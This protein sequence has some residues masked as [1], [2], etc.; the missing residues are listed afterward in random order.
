MDAACPACKKLFPSSKSVSG[1]RRHCDAYKT[2][3]QQVLQKRRQN[4]DKAE[5]S[6]KQ[7][8]RAAAE[9]ELRRQPDPLPDI[10][11]EPTEQ[12]EVNMPEVRIWYE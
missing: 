5:A 12:I 2:L 7:R 8:A 10:P 9:D 1:H 3:A 6:R 4:F 11:P